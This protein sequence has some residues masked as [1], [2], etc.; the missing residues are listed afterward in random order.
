MLVWGASTALLFALRTTTS[1]SMTAGK[2]VESHA[3]QRRRDM[4]I[5]N[6]TASRECLSGLVTLHAGMGCFD[7]VV[8]RVAHDNFAQ[9]DRQECGIPRLA[10]AARHGAPVSNFGAGAQKQD[11]RRRTG[12]S[13][14][15]EA[16]RAP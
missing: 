8:V 2:N 3:S 11:Q 13:A 5:R 16:R 10:K 9:H 7:C 15:H 12:V 14:P 4:G 1:L 6:S